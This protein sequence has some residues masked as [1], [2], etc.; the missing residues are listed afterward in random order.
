MSLL[1][2]LIPHIFFKNGRPKN[3]LILSPPAY[4]KTTLLRDLI[5]Q[6][7]NK[8]IRISIADERGELAAL[9]NGVAQFDIGIHT[10]VIEAPKAEAVLLLLKTMSPKIIALDEITSPNDLKAIDYAG[11]CGVGIFASSHAI[12][13]DDLK[14]RP[15]Y[16]EMMKLNIFDIIISLEKH[17]NT[18]KINIL[19]GGI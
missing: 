18:R 14:N 4:G 5:R 19:Q 8:G 17:E 2:S 12:N 6:V 3:V 11:N 9:N 16:S 13:T 1:A 10:D 7:S 15:L